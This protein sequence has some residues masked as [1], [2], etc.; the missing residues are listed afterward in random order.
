MNGDNQQ[1]HQIARLQADLKNLCRTMDEVKSGVSKIRDTLDE[2]RVVSAERA[3]MISGTASRLDDHEW[4][5]KKLEAS[6]AK[7]A[8]IVAL[9]AGGVTFGLDKIL[10][11]LK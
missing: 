6:S 10:G 5:I 8:L 1:T 7:L 9:T 11:V 3:A 2:H 4:R